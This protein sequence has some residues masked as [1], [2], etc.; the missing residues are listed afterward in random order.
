MIFAA[1]SG[2][3]K[4]AFDDFCRTVG[5]DE[6][7]RTDTDRRSAGDDKFDGIRSRP[8]SAHSQDRNTAF[9]SHVVVDLVDQINRDGFY[10]RAR[11][12]ACAVG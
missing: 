12:P 1:Q 8:D 5:L 6:I 10:R 7:R 3:M 9:F 11:K 4:F 2:S